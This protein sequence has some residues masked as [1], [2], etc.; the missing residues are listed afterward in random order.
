M[1]KSDQT[2]SFINYLVDELN[3][4][5]KF[6]DTNIFIKWT[7]ERIINGYYCLNDVNEG[8]IY[9]SCLVCRRTMIENV[10]KI[11]DLKF[12]NL[13]EHCKGQIEGTYRSNFHEMYIRGYVKE[14]IEYCLDCSLTYHQL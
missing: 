4:C 11:L 9:V 14:Q 7:P 8:G 13:C 3:S 2:E 10:R 5:C 1:S 12:G 6:R